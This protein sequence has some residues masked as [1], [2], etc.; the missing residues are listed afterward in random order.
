MQAPLTRLDALLALCLILAVPLLLSGCRTAK[1]LSQSDPQTRLLAA[2]TSV[3]LAAAQKGDLILPDP[4]ADVPPA[5]AAGY[6]QVS[7]PLRDATGAYIVNK[8]GDV[9]YGRRISIGKIDNNSKLAGMTKATLTLGGLE[10]GIIVDLTGTGITSATDAEVARTWATAPVAL[11]DAC[12]RAAVAALEQYKGMTMVATD[13]A[14]QIVQGALVAVTGVAPASTA[15]GAVSNLV[16]VL[17]KKT[18]G[19]TV[20]A[21]VSLPVPAA[22]QPAACVGA[23]CQAPGSEGAAFN[24]VQP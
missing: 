6:I 13:L 19:S 17:L 2:S 23:G 15:G 11:K 5:G 7:E 9:Q 22:L 12:G 21:K 1:L 14:G 16:T 3:R 8:A 18:D 24:P 4:L 20:P 10:A